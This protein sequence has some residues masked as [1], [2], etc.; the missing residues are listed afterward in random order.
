MSKEFTEWLKV[1]EIANLLGLSRVTIYKKLKQVN[2]EDLQ[3]LQ[4]VNNGITYYNVKILDILQPKEPSEE[5]IKEEEE[6]HKDATQSNYTNEYITSLLLQID[7]LKEQLDVKDEQ[8]TTKD[9]L[10]E[11]M[12]V[13]LKDKQQPDIKLLD[14]ETQSKEKQGFF[15]RLFR[16]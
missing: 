2:S 15:K 14:Q 4:Q 13:L 11:N 5:P 10:L 3:S 7:F 1:S 16:K 12:Q 9:R 8:L 6:H